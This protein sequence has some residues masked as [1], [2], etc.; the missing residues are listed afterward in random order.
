MPLAFAGLQKFFNFLVKSLVTL[1]F[2]T[3]A[4]LNYCQDREK[5]HD[6]EKK[7]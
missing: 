5:D 1:E 2:L 6:D 3:K 7:W 4:A